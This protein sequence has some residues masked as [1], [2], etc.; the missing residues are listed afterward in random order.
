M[1][2]HGNYAHVRGKLLRKIQEH[3]AIIIDFSDITVRKL[4]INMKRNRTR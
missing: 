4:E 1:I 3:K 2:L